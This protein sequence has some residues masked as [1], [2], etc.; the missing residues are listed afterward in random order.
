MLFFAERQIQWYSWAED[1]QSKI[2]WEA[3]PGENI[4]NPWK[5]EKSPCLGRTSDL[6][7]LYLGIPSKMVKEYFLTM[8]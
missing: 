5:K 7:L 6:L 1:L 4:G 2:E 8:W 3:D